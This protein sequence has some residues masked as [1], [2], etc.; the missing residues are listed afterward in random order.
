MEAT[1]SSGIFTSVLSTGLCLVPI[2]GL[3]LIFLLRS[4]GN[5]SSSTEPWVLK[6][7]QIDNTGISGAHLYIEARK[8]GLMSFILNLLGLDDS[9]SLKVTNGLISFR[10]SSLLG[11][12]QTSTGLTQIGSF[13]G[14][15]SKPLSLLFLG[16]VSFLAGTYVEFLF[17]SE[18]GEFSGFFVIGACLS[19]LFLIAYALQKNLM[20]GFETSG[21]AYYGIAFKRGILNGV[22]VDIAQVETAIT[23]VNLLIGSATLGSQGYMET[24]NVKKYTK[25]GTIGA[26]AVQGVPVQQQQPISNHPPPTTVVPEPLPAPPPPSKAKF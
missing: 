2:M 3:F 15:Y 21:G 4:R 20:F 26:V 7:F 5:G 9:A 24:Q 10:K 6:T 8:P 1:G 22:S 19:L 18:V 12:I 23:L 13:Q 14:G 16:M 25:Q 17:I 11:L